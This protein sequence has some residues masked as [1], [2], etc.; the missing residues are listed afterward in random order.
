MKKETF[1]SIIGFN[2]NQEIM[3][4]KIHLAFKISILH[5]F[6]IFYVM[7]YI[8]FGSIGRVWHIIFG[9]YIFIVLQNFYFNGCILTR[10]ER[11]LFNDDNYKGFI[12]LISGLWSG[13]GNGDPVDR[14]GVGVGHGIRDGIRDGRMYAE[15]GFDKSRLIFYIVSVFLIIGGGLWRLFVVDWGR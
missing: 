15:N 10:L 13:S 14:V 5:Y 9:L 8:L 2:E 6:I 11:R 7:L 4:N 3:N 12:T 1:L